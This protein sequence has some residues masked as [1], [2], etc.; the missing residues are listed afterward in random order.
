MA[1]TSLTESEVEGGKALKTGVMDTIRTNM[2]DLD[3]RISSGGGSV[4]I[5][6]ELINPKED[7]IGNLMWSD[8]AEADFQAAFGDGWDVVTDDLH[9]LMNKGSAATDEDSTAIAAADTL[10]TRTKIPQVS[11]FSTSNPGDHSHVT[12]V[13]GTAGGT[14][15]HAGSGS[16]VANPSTGSGGSHT[17]TVTGGG[18]LT[19][20]PK[21]RVSYL[22]IKVR[23]NT[24]TKLL[25]YRASAG[26]TLTTAKVTQ[27]VAGTSATTEIDVKVGAA[28][29][30]VSTV[31]ST[32]PSIAYTDGN[33]A[34]STNVA[35][36]STAVAINN[37]IVV[38]LT[39]VQLGKDS[40][41]HIQ[42]E[43]SYS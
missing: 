23:T 12:G 13:K 40:K 34:T 11:A 14:L 24:G 9:F 43:G 27:F 22:Y 4:V 16:N 3:S 6:N 29:G 2:D 32:K 38:D 19:T 21:T 25:V 10:A 17:H 26:L 1:F 30:S 7:P 42:L 31:F 39:A 33:Y 20:R 36:S 18:D 37:W 35:F 28:L 15:F 41:I 5:F 8:L